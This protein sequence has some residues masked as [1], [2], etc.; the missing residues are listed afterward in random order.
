MKK[1]TLFSFALVALSLASCKKTMTCHCTGT[2]T[3]VETKT[4]TITSGPT[5]TSSP[6][7]YTE[8][9]PNV[10]QATAEGKA[11]CISRKKTFTTSYTSGGTTTKDDITQEFTC[12]IK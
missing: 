4:G 12:T 6:E 5:T 11:D 10:T 1:I 9:L 8:E 7:E 3:Q 2:T